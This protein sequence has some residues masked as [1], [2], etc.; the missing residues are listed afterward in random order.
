MKNNFLRALLF[1]FFSFCFFI[2]PKISFAE[3]IQ[4][5]QQNIKIEKNSDVKIEETIIYDF[6]GAQKEK[7]GILRYIPYKYRTEKGNVFTDIK[8]LSVKDEKGINYKYTLKKE[9]GNIVIR[10]GE[11]NILVSG[12]K[13][14]K[15]TYIVRGVINYFQD[16]DELYWNVTGNGWNVPIKSA[17][18]NL[19]LPADKIEE[20]QLKATCYTGTY[21]SKESFC[22][23]SIFD[24]EFQFSVNKVLNPGEGLTIVA[25]WPKGI[26]RELNIFEKFKNFLLANFIILLPI[27]IFLFLFFYWLKY[28]RDPEGRGTIIA[29]YEP[30]S[31]ITPAE[32]Q[33]IMKEGLDIKGITATIIDLARRGYLKIREIERKTLGFFK[34]KSKDWEILKIKENLESESLTIYE[35]NLLSSL[36]DTYNNITLSSLKKRSNVSSFF[37]KFCTDVNDIVVSKGYFPSNPQKIKEIFLSIGVIIIFVSLYL[38]SGKLISNNI[39]VISLTTCGIIFILFSPAMPRRTK[40]GIEAKEKLLGFKDFLSVTEK[41]RV[42]FH[43]SPEVNPE[44]F[45]EYLPYA[46]VFGVEKEWAKLFEGIEMPKPDWYEGAWVGGYSALVFTDSLSKFNSGLS[47]SIN[48]ASAAAGGSSGFGGGGFSGGG[49]GGGGGG[50]W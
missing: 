33:L 9:D 42:K 36:F 13:V 28:G 50:S 27:T 23:S 31:G 11:E 10:I 49:F 7:H 43:F 12:V 38:I 34:S 3:E 6:S 32:A 41:D 25:V 20:N 5:F 15:I 46:I 8:V 19:I 14:Y 47:S 18:A 45:A 44:K 1:I 37:D 48:S 40:K 21:G 24:K 2:F 16:H 4:L 39:S 22:S 29:E 17:K 30:P 26:V 35:R